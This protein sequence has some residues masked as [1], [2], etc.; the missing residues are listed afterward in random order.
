MRI[1]L[2]D[3]SRTV[4]KIVGGQLEAQGHEVRPFV[5]G[6]ETLEFI[7][8]D[9]VVSALITSTELQSMSG[10]ELCWNARMLA[11]RGRP[12]YVILMSSNYHSRK[13]IEALD[14]GADD[15]M[16]KPPVAE[17]LYA[18]LRAAE[19]VVSMQRELIRL[20]D[21]DAMTGV[22]NRR[23]F[24]ERAVES[25]ARANDGEPLC[26]VMM[27]IDHFKQINDV[28]G[29]AVGDRAIVEVARQAGMEGPIV[30][31]LGGEEFGILLEGRS[32]SEA[33]DWADLVRRNIEQLRFETDREPLSLTCSFGLSEWQAGDDI[34]QLLRRADT[35]LYAAKMRGRNRTVAFDAVMLA[36]TGV[37]G[38]VRARRA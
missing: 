8:S 36:M 28:Y 29:H 13:L 18:R 34:D 11:S 26:G 21:T 12:L 14:G 9:A 32:L 37:R 6:A 1:A 33:H 2:V 38:V 5:D 31:R 15:F 3:P 22:F 30:G 27:D 20:A 23:A 7:K 4:L 17:E 25:C 35:A 19:R 10:M 24:F 16:G